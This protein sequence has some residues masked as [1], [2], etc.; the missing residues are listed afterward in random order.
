[1]DLFF[2]LLI[3]LT[4]AGSAIVVFILLLQL[5]SPNLFPAKWRYTIGK[6]AILFYVFPVAFFVKWIVQ[7][8]PQGQTL[9]VDTPAIA[10][11]MK[12]TSTDNQ[13]MLIS[14]QIIPREIAW[15]L[16]ILWGI[17]TITFAL[18]Q[19]YCYRRFMRSM[20]ETAS[21]I[22]VDCE[23]AKQLASLKEILKIKGKIQLA[24]SPSIK[25][26]VLIGLLKPIILLPMRDKLPIDLGMAIHHELI[27][28]RRKDLWIKM[29][30]LAVGAIH[31]FNP[32][33]HLLRKDIH[34]WSELSCDDEVVRNMAYSER[35]R[36]GEM[37]LN[38]MIGSRGLPIKFCSSLSGD[39]KQLK[40]RLAMMLNVKNP[41]KQIVFITVL[42]TLLI[43]VIA[44]TTAAWAANRT[45]EVENYPKE[46]IAYD[47]KDQ[48]RL[49]TIL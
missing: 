40:R 30:A 7:F 18:W 46:Q 19:I 22:S 10:M 15:I 11:I 6:M 45:P 34:L 3:T 43:G 48:R 1:M 16:L 14:K 9:D 28:L 25:S 20:K 5:I 42:L 41:Q 38:V 17:G 37:I 27:H 23:A 39:G 31:W 24:Y 8:L 44:T 36:Y 32:F 21:L 35:K 29:F 4:V 12:E 2:G 33:A 47:E 49:S 26:P 13:T